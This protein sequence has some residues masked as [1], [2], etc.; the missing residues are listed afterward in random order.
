MFK[1]KKVE[2]VWSSEDL[3]MQ[4]LINSMFEI[5]SK[6][7]KYCYEIIVRKG[8]SEMLPEGADKNKE[9]EEIAQYQHRILCLIG[10][11]DDDLR[12]Y[13]Q[14]D[15][16]KLVHY[17]GKAPRIT[18]HELLHQCWGRAYRKVMGESV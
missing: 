2:P 6:I 17:T 18:S 3:Q 12:Q 1:R 4:L 13:N 5:S 9:L 16:S 8:S 10:G 11:Y 7:G 15:A 14:I